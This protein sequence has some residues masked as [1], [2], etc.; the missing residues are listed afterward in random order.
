M[1]MLMN[2]YK[3]SMALCAVGLIFVAAPKAEATTVLVDLELSLLIDVSGSVDDTEYALQR[4]GYA[5]A[6]RDPAIQSAIIGGALGNI[7]VN[8]IQFDDSN[9]SAIPWTLLASAADAIAFADLLDNMARLGS[10]STGIGQGIDAAAS[11]LLTNG[12]DGNRLVIDVSGDGE[13]NSGGEPS[14][15]RDAAIAGGI[16]TINGITV[17]DPSGTLRQ[18]YQ[19]NVIGGANAFARDAATFQDFEAE[20]LEKILSEIRGDNLLPLLS[21]IQ[22]STISSAISATAPVSH[23]LVGIR[24]GLTPASTDVQAP[25]PPTMDAKGGMSAKAPF[26]PAS[27]PKLWEIYGTLF[28][29]EQ[30]TDAKSSRLATGAPIILFPSTDTETFGGT[31]GIDRRLTPEWLLGFA[32]TAS[33]SDVSVGGVG[34]NADIDGY[35]LTPYVSYVRGDVFAG[36]DYYFDALYSFGSQSYDIDNVG[37][38]GDTDGNTHSIQANT[39]LKFK[40]GSIKHGPFV[41]LRWLTGDIDAYTANP[42][43]AV[44]GTD[45]DSFV[46]RLGYEIAT[47]VPMSGGMLMPYANVTWEHEFEDESV[48][49]GGVPVSIADEDTLVLGVGVAA[50]LANGWTLQTEYEGRFGDDITQHYVG[51]RVGYEF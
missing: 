26:E 2:M 23:R 35:Y 11:S 1:K 30:E 44:P 27:S 10:G 31:V 28:Y 25:A 8:A 4:S 38:I 16:D 9:Y 39:G 7:A 5:N 24:N 20:V 18:Y 6:F 33:N 22:N 47:T 46:S 21:T 37:A 43:G 14:V 32:F 50:N 36:A 48:L 29:V 12:F 3:R 19:D 49:V 42:G 45:F 15:A 51:L 13:N 40:S 17:G 34:A 41:G